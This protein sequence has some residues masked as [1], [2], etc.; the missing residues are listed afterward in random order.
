MKDR[1]LIFHFRQFAIIHAKSAMKVGT[2]GVLL[3]A[4]A[5]IEMSENMLDIGTG[6][7]LIALMVAQRNP[8]V[9]IHAIEPDEVA[10]NEALVNVQNSPWQDRISVSNTKLQ[11]HQGK[12]DSLI[13]N[14]PYF[15]V[16]KISGGNSSRSRARQTFQLSQ[17]EII[18]A[19][20][21]L[22]TET[23]YLHLILPVQEGKKFIDLAVLKGLFLKR[24]CM[25]YSDLNQPV[26]RMMT[27]SSTPQKMSQETLYIRKDGRYTPEY[28]ALTSSFYTGLKD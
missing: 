13:T 10:F 22:L 12:Y 8:E 26:R 25:V 15:E 19:A 14:P 5:D 7:G 20:N 3:G 4:W 16:N 23:G 6:T 27:F 28:R 17:L 24:H 2:D 1:K 21:L 9:K 11:E 18:D